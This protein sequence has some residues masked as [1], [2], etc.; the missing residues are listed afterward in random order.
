MGEKNFSARISR[1]KID[2]ARE[3]L[4]NAKT[5]K[6]RKYFSGLLRIALDDYEGRKDGGMSKAVMKARGGT[7]K[8]I[9]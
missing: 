8:G 2:K 3:G 6:D 5:E 9:F 4:A 7:F 1:T